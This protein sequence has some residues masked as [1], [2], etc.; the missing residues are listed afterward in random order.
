[1]GRISYILLS[2]LLALEACGTVPTAGPTYSQIKDQISNQPKPLFDFVE[3]NQ[4]VVDDVEKETTP[5]A[6]DPLER[7]GRPPYQLIGVGDTVSVSVWQQTPNGIVGAAP[8]TGAAQPTGGVEAAEAGRTLAIPDQVVGVDGGIT[9]PYAGRIR[10]AGHTPFQ[11]E[12]TIASLLSQEMINP[13]VVVTVSKDTS[14]QVTV[15]G[16]LLAGGRIPLSPGGNRVLEVI[17]MAGGVK[18]PL[19][20]TYIRI[21]RKNV[22]A[23]VPME[24]LV[25]DPHADIFLWPGDVVAVLQSPK[26]FS[27]FGATTNNPVIPIDS[28]NLS[29]AEAIAKA[30]GLSDTRADPAAVFLFRFEQQQVARSLGAPDIQGFDKV[31]PVLYRLN[32]RQANGYFLASQ[33]PIRNKDLIYVANAPM[34]DLQKFFTLIG[35]ITGPVISGAIIAR[36]TGH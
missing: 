35:T 4:N 19:R 3:I 27:V 28:D 22:T 16:D 10:V 29:L 7:L 21:T 11:V 23:T 14:N 2:T 24:E 25:S 12:R 17:A 34:T 30:G 32:L 18:S 5:A 6:L 1:M 20:D 36:P 9:V 15:V 8:T 33:F 26:T 31:T 13:Q